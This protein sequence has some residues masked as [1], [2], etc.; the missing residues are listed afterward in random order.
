M[1]R[2]SVDAPALMKQGIQI[3]GAVA[4]KQEF[5]WRAGGPIDDPPSCHSGPCRDRTIP[6]QE[7]SIFLDVQE[8]V[9]V[10]NA[11]KTARLPG[12]DGHVGNRVL[13]AGEEFVSGQM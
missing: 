12:P 13:V 10:V 1:V 6:A 2:F 11:V 3:G 4:F 8:L 9:R 7:M 5:A